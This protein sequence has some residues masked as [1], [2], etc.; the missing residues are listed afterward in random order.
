MPIT[1]YPPW[2]TMIGIHVIGDFFS[3]LR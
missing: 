1:F 3:P 2:E